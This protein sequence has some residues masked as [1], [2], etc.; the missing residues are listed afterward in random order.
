MEENE[1]K[2]FYPIIHRED[3]ELVQSY[4]LTFARYNFDVYEKRIMYYIIYDK[5]IQDYIRN[6]IHELKNH[7]GG[8][9]KNS[10]FQLKKLP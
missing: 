5:K 4:I 10:L 3:R 9:K 7:I 2:E 6:Y 8:K 1:N